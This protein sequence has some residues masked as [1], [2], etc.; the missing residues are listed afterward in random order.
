MFSRQYIRIYGSWFLF[1]S[2]ATGGVSDG[3]VQWGRRNC[4]PKD[5]TLFWHRYEFMVIPIDK[6]VYGH[7]LSMW[8]LTGTKVLTGNKDYLLYMPAAN[9]SSCDCIVWWLF[10]NLRCNTGTAEYPNR[11][12][13]ELL[14]LQGKSYGIH[15]EPQSSS[16]RQEKRFRP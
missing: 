7:T 6:M 8:L 2:L 4:F 5:L 15:K 14:D 3:Y 16:H 1:Q 12:N 13:T 9:F 11:N 10:F